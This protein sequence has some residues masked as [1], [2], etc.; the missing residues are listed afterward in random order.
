MSKTRKIKKSNLKELKKDLIDD[1]DQFLLDSEESPV[2][3]QKEKVKALGELD[4]LIRQDL[5]Y[6]K[7]LTSI[8]KEV[9]KEKVATPAK[10]VAK[11]KPTLK[12]K[13]VI[14]KTVKLKK[15]HVVK[16]ALAKE[17]SDKEIFKS[18]HVLDLS[19]V[20]RTYAQQPSKTSRFKLG[21]KNRLSQVQVK[22]QPTKISQP[23]NQP[24]VP[25]VIKH[26]E[27]IDSEE[28]LYFPKHT[29]RLNISL[30]KG[31][32]WQ[33][34][35]LVPAANKALVFGL[36]LAVIL[37][38]IRGLVLFG[39]IQDDKDK[40]W[41]FGQSGLINLQAGVI[42]ASENSYQ[43]AQEDFTK[44]LDDFS[45]AQAVLNQHQ[46]WSLN[47][48]SI[49]PVVGKPLSLSRNMLTVAT[50]ISQAAT[51]LNQKIQ[52]E[53]NLTEYIVFINQQIEDVLPYLEK[54]EEDLFS[55]STNSLPSN[56]RPQ[57]EDLKTYLPATVENLHSLNNIF[58][59][60]LDMLGHD[61]EKRYLVLFQNNNELRATGGFIGSISMFDVYQGNINNIETPKGGSYD[62]DAGQVIKYKAPQALSL[63]NPYFNIWDANWWADF[64]SS[65]EK[66]GNM[67]ENASGTSINGVIAINA[68]VLRELLLVIGPITMEE[69]GVTISA[70]NLYA[71]LQDEVELNYDQ[72]ENKPKAIISDLV[73]KVLEKLLTNQEKQKDIIAVFAGMLAS[74]DIQLYSTNQEIQSRINDFGWSGKIMTSDKDYLSVINTNIA[75]G[76]TDNDIY[77][78]ID[79]QAE[80]NVNGEIINTVKITRINRGPLENPFAGIEGGNVSYVRVHVPLGSE[81]IEAIGFDRLPDSYFNTA[82]PGA[83]LDVDVAKEE[84]KMVDMNSNTEIY[85]S[86]DKTVFANWIALKPGESQTALVKYKLP[87]RLDLSDPLVNN[88]VQNIFQY[89]LQLDN[90][91]LLVQSQSGSK[92]TVFN[93]SIL[94]PD[95]LKVVWKNAYNEDNVGITENL[96]TYSEQLNRDQYFGFIVATK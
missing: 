61:T 83:Q 18:S 67:Y 69:Y 92:N 62:L 11:T 32:K 28:K 59:L 82:A 42:S 14:K 37:L 57:F 30:P 76:K 63:I 20:K 35:G 39:K 33:P 75:G 49:L 47:V 10:L 96:V 36:I 17:I 7:I 73:P 52:S 27:V 51:I 58:T 68:E 15:K 5:S 86:L 88:W 72:E 16:K 94:V 23:A 60:L 41:N 34:L 65:A 46:E 22:K 78:T 56:L 93:S 89:D 50:N 87:F 71:V 85:Q 45:Q 55:I 29:P 3:R 84:E 19:K 21:L 24:I 43:V 2:E 26:E 66:I 8:K 91:S 12:S 25:A 44:A 64:P 31:F 81:F 40:V 48:A 54:A 95:N 53:E 74:K 80:I 79:H 38:P 90:Y 9:V 4:K 6:N 70:D 13:T 1:L 77:Q